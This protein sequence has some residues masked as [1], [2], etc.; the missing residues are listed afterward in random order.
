MFQTDVLIL[1]ENY[2]V[3]LHIAKTLQFLYKIS[4]SFALL[5]C[6][7]V[8]WQGNCSVVSRDS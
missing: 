6:N 1:M 8:P 2:L 7:K 4:Y 3:G 5:H